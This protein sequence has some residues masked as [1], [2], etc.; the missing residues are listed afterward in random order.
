MP[1]GDRLEESLK[2]MPLSGDFPCPRTLSVVI[3]AYNEEAAIVATIQRCQNALAFLGRENLEILVVDDGST[4]RT[5]ELARQQGITVQRHPTKGGY[6]LSL[7]DGIRTAKFD[8]IAISDADGSY[9]VEEIPTLLEKYAQGFDM[10]VGARTGKHFRG[11]FL[12]YPMRLISRWMVEFTVG[13]RIPDV[14]S[15]LRIFSKQ[16]CMAL[17]NHLCNH[18]SFTTSLTLGYIMGSKFLASV[19][20]PFFARVGVSKVRFSRDS[21][22][23]LQFIVHAILYYNPLKIFLLLCAV[24]LIFAFRC[25]TVTLVA[26]LTSTFLLGLGSI[27][28]SFIIFSLG[29]LAELMHQIMIK[30]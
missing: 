4:D 1:S 3:P 18:F 21:L 5:G 19:P 12:K 24:I 8:T 7:K 26:H 6:G 23:T 17:F 27:L 20:I 2:K 28:P 30:D 14:N 13:Q 15:G 11:T 29:L 25:F 9:P 16:E 10:V 22:R